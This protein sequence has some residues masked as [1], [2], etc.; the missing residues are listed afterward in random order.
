MPTY[1]L[2]QNSLPLHHESLADDLVKNVTKRPV[3]QF[4]KRDNEHRQ[5]KIAH[6]ILR[7]LFKLQYYL[8]SLE[9]QSKFNKIPESFDWRSWWFSVGICKY[10]SGYKSHDLIKFQ[11]LSLVE[12]L[13][14]KEIHYKIY[15]PV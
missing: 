12:N 4:E 13:F 3:L 7:T 10:K 14:Q 6:V 1:Y 5:I 15:S 9:F 8:K 11:V 2:G